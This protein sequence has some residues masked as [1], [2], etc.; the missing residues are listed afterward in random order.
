MLSQYNENTEIHESP[1]ARRSK[2]R[3]KS[4]PLHFVS[5]QNRTQILTKIGSVVWGCSNPWQP[6]LDWAPNQEGS[7]QSR[8]QGQPTREGLGNM[9]RACRD[10]LR[11][12]TAHLRLR[13]MSVR[14]VSTPTR[15]VKGWPREIWACCCVGIYWFSDSWYQW[16]G[17]TQCL[18]RLTV[19]RLL[20]SLKVNFSLGFRQQ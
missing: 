7:T 3:R 5:L 12:A 8:E 19:Q 16:G 18:L 9:A 10:A 13:L 14:T 15:A 4:L 6:R 11:K 1:S 17:G 2:H 20:N